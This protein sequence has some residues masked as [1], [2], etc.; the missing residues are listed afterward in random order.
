MRRGHQVYR[1]FLPS[2]VS[3]AKP[4]PGEA[5][6]VNGE[7]FID[8]AN[9]RYGWQLLAHEACMIMPA[10]ELL[11][12]FLIVN[13]DGVGPATANAMWHS[14]VNQ[15]IDLPK[16]LDHGRVDLL[17]SLLDR[18]NKPLLAPDFIP[19][20]LRRWQELAVQSE[21]M[22]W[23]QQHGFSKTLAR[24]IRDAWGSEAITVIEDNPYRL[25]AFS[26]YHR[27]AMAFAKVDAIATQKL[28]L[29]LD[30]RRR[31]LAA[32]ECAMYQ[33]WDNGNTAT[34]LDKLNDRLDALLGKNRTSTD[35][36]LE[37]AAANFAVMLGSHSG[38]QILV[39]LRGVALLEHSISNRFLRMIDGCEA[40]QDTL[41]QPTLPDSWACQ[42]EATVRLQAGRHDFALNHGQKAALEMAI[43]QPLSVITGDAG[44]GKTTTLN[45]LFEL[46]LAQGGSVYPMAPTGKA[47][48]RVRESTGQSHAS[49]I[50]KF[51]HE[52]KRGRII[53]QPGAYVVIDEASMVDTATLYE[54][55]KYTPPG[56]RLVFVGDPYQ[57]PPI[58]AGLTFHILA[59]SPLVPTA[60]LSEVH[61]AAAET[62]I[63]A[64][65]RCIREQKMPAMDKIAYRS[66]ATGRIIGHDTGVLF[67]TAD[68]GEIK[69]AVIRAYRELKTKGDVQIIAA[70]NRAGREKPPVG[71]SDI[72]LLLQELFRSPDRKILEIADYKRF[73]ENDPVIFT[74]NIA[75]RD[76]WNGSM[77]RLVKV[78]DPPKYGSDG[79]DGSENAVEIVATVE[80]D[81]VE[82]HLSLADFER[83][84]LAYAVTC[85]KSQG[86]AF[87]RVIVISHDSMVMDNTW[88]Y[89][90]L[91]RAKKQVVIIGNLATMENHVVNAP[92][93]FD[94]IVGLKI[95]K[96]QNDEV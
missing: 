67:I 1:V 7:P 16:A 13:F 64:A 19:V 69:D 81:G 93:S 9:S 46:I 55:L 38:Q 94:R 83:I 78:F 25:L 21:A 91:T 86:S 12:D 3:D 95:E 36:I 6:Q 48:K 31:L 84:D 74:K 24:R 88:F 8:Q 66:D 23:M 50:A 96:R 57:L 17:S 58:G 11:I 22:R 85:H 2:D 76:L 92:R 87:D 39:Q 44:T 71:V 75:A 20:L 68:P 80:L 37:H 61:R 89:T 4:Q 51:I 65:A 26:P 40:Y 42:F 49:T 59:T 35:D 33:E 79:A 10:G 28:N 45:A 90:A 30:D 60:M 29:A 72:N 15:A 77:G 70:I 56:S 73:I 62:G 32:F 47:A 52:R 54:L 27:A 41:F 14:A 82:R 43:M 18:K 63:P 34:T 53:P 5:W